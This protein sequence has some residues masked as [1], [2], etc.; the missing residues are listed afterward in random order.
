MEPTAM[1]TGQLRG[2][3]KLMNIITPVDVLRLN[4]SEEK[5]LYLLLW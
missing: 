4:K 1:S 3:I 2:S 5:L